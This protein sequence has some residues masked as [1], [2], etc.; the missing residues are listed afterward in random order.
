METAITEEDILEG[1]NRGISKVLRSIAIQT[2]SSITREQLERVAKLLDRED[3]LDK[4]A[5]MAA[6]GF[7]LV[8]QSDHLL[9]AFFGIRQPSRQRVNLRDS[10]G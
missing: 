5:R 6:E 3:Y 2:S 8:V 9:K 4:L 7:R 10:A 1:R